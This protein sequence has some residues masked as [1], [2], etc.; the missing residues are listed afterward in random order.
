ML[1]ESELEINALRSYHHEKWTKEDYDLV[2]PNT[3]NSADDK[4][5]GIEMRSLNDSTMFEGG[6]PNDND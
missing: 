3:S 6:I 5:D 1:F 4:G 2:K